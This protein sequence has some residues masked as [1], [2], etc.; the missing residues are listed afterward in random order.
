MDAIAPEPSEPTEPN[1]I[2]DNLMTLSVHSLT[3]V[4]IYE[5]LRANTTNSIGFSVAY[6]HKT[7]ETRLT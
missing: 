2:P 3:H 6:V 4:M 1:Q 7:S 5:T